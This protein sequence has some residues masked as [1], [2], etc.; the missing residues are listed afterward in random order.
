MRL[1]DANINRWNLVP[2]Y[3]VV[4]GPHHFDGNPT[5]DIAACT[6]V[7]LTPLGGESAGQAFQFGLRLSTHKAF[8]WDKKGVKC[9]C[10]LSQASK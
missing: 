4:G 8:Y 9:H 6:G 7:G 5:L 2:P 10:Y 3:L 1:L